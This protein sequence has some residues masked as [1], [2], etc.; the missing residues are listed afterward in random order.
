MNL[1]SAAAGLGLAG[2]VIGVA[3]NGNLGAL[4][5]QLKKEE[6]YLE[7]A[8]AIVIVWALAKYGPTSEITDGLVIAAVVAVA[9]KMAGRLN[10]QP[11]LG[12]F[13]SG[14]ASIQ[15]TVSSIFSQGSLTHAG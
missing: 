5:T 4:W 2:Y 3:L 13:A 6:P 14:Q 9:L 11:A 10:L 12:N 15:Q 7:F 8:F 1:V